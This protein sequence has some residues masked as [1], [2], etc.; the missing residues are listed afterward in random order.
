MKKTIISMF[1]LILALVVFVNAQIITTGNTM[2]INEVSNSATQSNF[3]ELYFSGTGSLSLT[4]W[5]LEKD[6]QTPFSLSSY[7]MDNVARF[8]TIDESQLG[9]DLSDSG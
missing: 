2:F 7:V 1:I 3:V 5:T 6:G 4:G 8:R 9:Y